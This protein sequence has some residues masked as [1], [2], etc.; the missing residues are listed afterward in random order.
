MWISKKKYN[1]LKSSYKRYFKKYME[2][3]ESHRELEVENR[4]IKIRFLHYLDQVEKE[5]LHHPSENISVEDFK[6]TTEKIRKM[7]II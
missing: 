6:V 7:L 3:L 1:N 4:A 2:C 5:I